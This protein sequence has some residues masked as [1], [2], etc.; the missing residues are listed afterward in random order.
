MDQHQPEDRPTQPGEKELPAMPERKYKFLRIIL[1]LLILLA[2]VAA[3]AGLMQSGPKAKLR[4]K[5]RNATLVDVRPVTFAAQ[6]TTISVM[7]TVIPQLMVALNPRVSGEIIRVSDHLI[8]G[9]HFLKE[10]PLLTIDPS[11]YQLMVRQL[12]SEV[13]RAQADYQVE[14]GYQLV[15]KKEFTL[16]NEEVS[17]EEQAL[18]LREPQLERSRAALQSAQAKLA[19]AD[20]DLQRTVVK[21]PFNAIVMSRNVNLGTRVTPATPLATLV[22]SDAYWVEASIPASQLKWIDTD[23]VDGT[24]GSPVRIYDTASWGSDSYRKGEVVGL[25]ATVEKQGRMARILISIPDPLALR[26]EH[27]GAERLLLDTYV[28][29]EIDGRPLEQATVIERDLL[30]DGDKVWIMNDAG[31]LDIRSV[32]IAFRNQNEVLVTGGLREGEQ[33]IISNLPSPVAGM[34]LRLQ[35]DP[36]T[37]PATQRKTTP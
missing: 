18:M 14:Q 3:S 17:T 20:L 27:T 37:T 12:A 24:P 31:K 36:E 29:V 8:P 16:L 34:A 6:Q 7:G 26:P 15:A 2:A 21:A 9:G 13:A 22:G 30:R 35:D 19:Q 1:P 10:E 25:T 4:P 33:L 5:P 28:R 32:E 11:D 23:R